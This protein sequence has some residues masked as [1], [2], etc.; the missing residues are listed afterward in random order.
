[1]P[2]PH[3]A[4]WPLPAAIAVTLLLA[5]H[6]AWALS[7]HAGTIPFCVPYVEGCT[8]ISRAAREGLANA[9]FRLLMLPLALAVALHWWLAARWLARPGARTVLAAG[10]VSA[11][12]LAVYATFLGTDGQAYR[13]LRRNGVVAFF[14]A[15]FLAQ[16]AFLRALGAR[17]PAAGRGIA[18]AL[19][20]VCW[21]MLSIGL[22]HVAALAV[23]GGSAFQDR[24]ENALEWLLGVGLVAWFAL[25]ASLWRRVGYRLRQVPHAE[26]GEG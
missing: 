1:M 16:V 3:I 21:A 25:H 4:L 18:R 20:A 17:T 14:G 13:F 11:A 12:A 22:V 24:F 2:R 8:S 23:A 5:T 19:R 26:A 9:V 15:G 7:V 6:A 10:L